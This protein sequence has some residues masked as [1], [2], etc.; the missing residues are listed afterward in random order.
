[1]QN[2]TLR[3]RLFQ[4]L[5]QRF[6]YGW[7][8]V[9]IGMLALFASGPGQS[10]TFSVF[11]GPVSSELG[12]SQ[13]MWGTAYGFATLIAAFGLPY[14]GRLT[15]RF[16]PRNMLLTVAVLLGTACIAFGA[17]PGL[18]SLGL[19]FAAL[20]FLGQRNDNRSSRLSQTSHT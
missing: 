16:G 18:L 11:L 12:L 17:A 9:A 14:M 10:H 1:M 19:G 7:T 6:F 3:D 5:S 20:R 4:R 13:T 15:D 2:Q 8:I